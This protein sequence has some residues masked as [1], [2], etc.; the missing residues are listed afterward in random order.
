MSRRVV[1]VSTLIHYLKETMEADPVL[2]GVMIEGEISNLRR[3]YSG[4]WYFSIKDSKASLPCVMFASRNRSVT[5]SPK[6]GDKV[7]LT[8]DVSVYEAEGR[9]QMIVSS[10]R[11]SGVGDL[12]LQLEALKKKL[13]EKGYFEETH[14]KPI[15]SYAVNI[16]LVTGNNTAAKADVLKTLHSRWPI[17]SITEYPAPVQGAEAVPKIIEALVK[18]DRHNHQIVLLVR[19]GGSLEDLW[20]F[21]DEALAK[22]IYSMKTPVITGIGHEIDFTIADYVAD[23]RANTPTGAAEAAVPDIKEVR[24]SLCKYKSHMISLVKSRAELERKTFDN[25]AESNVF[26]RSERLYSEQELLLNNLQEKLMSYTSIPAEKRNNLHEL[27]QEFNRLMYAYTANIR[28]ILH[29]S[30][31]R[32]RILANTRLEQTKNRIQQEQTELQSSV[33]KGL[34]ERMNAF[35]KTASLLDAYSPVKV[36]ARG[37]SVITD[38]GKTIS[39]VNDV[40]IGDKIDVTV[41]DGKLNAVIKEKSNG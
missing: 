36:L 32:I 5:F 33:N 15:P 37:Y 25:A 19:G 6:D 7:I 10:M 13:L 9:M 18:A 34:T 31:S 22:T 8:G 28:T 29:T 3:P 21:N 4:H 2:H 16:A 12:Y 40:S 38:N 24:N 41:S 39:S 17:A 1:A 35:S 23:L 20:C 14:K 27:L 30:D 11:P 26:T